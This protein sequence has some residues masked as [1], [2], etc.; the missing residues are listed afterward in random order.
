MIPLLLGALA[1]GVLIAANWDDIVD[2]IRDSVAKIKE[3]FQTWKNKITILV[4]KVKEDIITFIERVRY[5]ENGEVIE[6]LTER[7]IDESEVPAEILAR[8][9]GKR[10]IDVTEDM[11]KLMELEL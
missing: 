8:V 2:W 11:S 1:V 9:K 7:E 3:A 4:K 10:K 5:R 6:K